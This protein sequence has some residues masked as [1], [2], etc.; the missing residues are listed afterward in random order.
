MAERIDAAAVVAGA[1]VIVLGVLLLLDAGGTLE[2][3]FA[4]LG[5][6]A[7]VTVGATLLAAGLTRRG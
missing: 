7:C 6:L 1:F 5:P 2:L 4:A 3:P